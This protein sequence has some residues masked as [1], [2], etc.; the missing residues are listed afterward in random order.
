MFIIEAPTSTS[1]MGCS[2][3]PSGAIS[4]STR[5][6]SAPKE[7]M[8]SLPPRTA[9]LGDRHAVF[10]LFLR[11]AAIITSTSSAVGR[12]PRIWKS[13]LT[14]SFEGNVLIGLRFD[15]RLEFVLAQA[16]PEP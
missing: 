9:E 7:S 2:R 4:P 16:G 13:G 8:S 3:P 15:L 6:P 5:R 14:P 11:E 10:D 12:G 1:A